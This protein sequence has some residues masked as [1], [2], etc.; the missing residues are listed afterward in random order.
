VVATAVTSFQPGPD[1]AAAYPVGTGVPAPAGALGP[2]A[3]AGG[4]NHPSAAPGSAAVSPHARRVPPQSSKGGA[5][6]PE[7]DDVRDGPPSVQVHPP[8]HPE[9]ESRDETLARV[10]EEVEAHE[11]TEP[12]A[13]Q[14]PSTRRGLNRSLWRAIGLLAAGGFV[15]GAVLGLILSFV[16]GPFEL[17]GRGNVEG[18]TEWLQTLAYTLVLGGAVALVT[19]VIGTLIFLAREDGRVEREVEETTGTEPVAPGSP[20]DPEHDPTPR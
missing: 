19:V 14:D 18:S 20:G 15:V 5:A 2:R 7:H 3:I 1:E 16:Q 10:A 4:S 9:P 11:H 6:I 8:T 12:V 17:V 13:P